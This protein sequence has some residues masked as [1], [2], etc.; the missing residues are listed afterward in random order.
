MVEAEEPDFKKIVFNWYFWVS[1]KYQTFSIKFWVEFNIFYEKG[2]NQAEK[3]GCGKTK[4]K[5]RF[6]SKYNFSRFDL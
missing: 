2:Y 1:I 3:G 6:D 4:I 5:F